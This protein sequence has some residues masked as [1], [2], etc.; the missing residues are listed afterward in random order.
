MMNNDQ[1]KS[2]SL[3]RRDCL[4]IHNYISINIKYLFSTRL[5]TCFKAPYSKVPPKIGDTR[6]TVSPI[7][8]LSNLQRHQQSQWATWRRPNH[9]PPISHEHQT[10]PHSEPICLKYRKH[11][12]R[13]MKRFAILAKALVHVHLRSS[14]VLCNC[15]SDV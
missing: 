6:A 8:S 1:R 5:P 9:S 2:K 11:H 10:T 12:R 14:S 15:Q 3:D 4:L 7:S 13:K